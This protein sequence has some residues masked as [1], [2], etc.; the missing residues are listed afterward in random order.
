MAIFYEHIKGCGPQNNYLSWIKWSD[1]NEAPT[2]KNAKYLPKV[3]VNTQDFGNIITSNATDQY[4]YTPLS[5]LSGIT[6]HES[7]CLE[8]DQDCQIQ[9]EFG[10]GNLNLTD[11]NSISC[12]ATDYIKFTTEYFETQVIEATELIEAPLIKATTIEA[13]TIDV[14]GKCQAQYFNATSDARAKSNITPAQFFALDV[15]KQLPIYTFNYLN[16]PKL[17]IGLIAQEAAE[18]DLD[19]FNMVD[20]LDAAGEFGDYMQMKESKLVYVLWKAV[21]E[22]TDEVNSLKVQIQQ[23]ENK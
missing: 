17:S 21:Q 22:L 8:Y 4:I 2:D 15:I 20:N 19:G 3:K 1:E 11:A 5:F 6:V 12:S 13:T 10:Q 7:V 23:L 14:S 18:H 9:I 16:D